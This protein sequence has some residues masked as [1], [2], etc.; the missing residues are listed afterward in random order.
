M[1]L[2]RFSDEY[3]NNL[4]GIL[5]GDTVYA[6]TWTGDMLGL[7][8]SGI[9]PVMS[10][11]YRY[12][13]EKVKIQ[14]PYIPPKIVCIGRNYADH[15]Q[16]MGNAV[17]EK[18]FLFGKFSSSIIGTGDTIRWSEAITTKVD[19]EGELAV[20]IG[21]AG[22]NIKSENAYD[23]VFGYSIANDVSARDLQEND[24]QWARAKG[25]DTF[26]PFGPVIVTRDEISD[27]HDLTL[28]TSVN[29]EQV[30]NTNTS[31][32]IHKIPDL[33]AY[34]SAAFALEV[35]DVILTGTPAGVG[36]GM[37]P[38]RYLKTGDVVSVS[39]SGIGTLQN[40]CLSN[41]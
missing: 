21:K 15:A 40:S 29:G 13:I 17:P 18:P 27:P 6:T 24:G 5:D 10:Y 38:P 11:A 28:T 39:I 33:I 32:M 16:E 20:I 22:R 19:W 35:G 12:P 1:K 31:L 14:S 34:I 30:Q 26:C 9:K 7:M 2:I 37:K 3:R 8:R 41:S 25:M 36:K 23:H 4:V